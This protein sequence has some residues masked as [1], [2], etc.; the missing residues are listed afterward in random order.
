ME[1]L[2][3]KIF[4]PENHAKQAEILRFLKQSRALV[5]ELELILTENDVRWMDF[6]AAVPADPRRPEAVD[7]IVVT[8]AAAGELEVDW[9]RSVRSNRFRVEVLVPGPGATYKR[10]A[11]VKD[12]NASLTGLTP[13]VEVQ[14]RVVAV[15]E[16]DEAAPSDPVTVKVPALAD[17]A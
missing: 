17:A 11:T 1:N 15:N 12:S 2:F 7:V 9:E 16:A 14:V 13:G 5:S 8:G 4:P 10:V 3:P 6:V